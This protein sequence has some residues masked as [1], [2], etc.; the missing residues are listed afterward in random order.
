MWTANRLKACR[1]FWQAPVN[2]L[3]ALCSRQWGWSVWLFLSPWFLV[4]SLDSGVLF[5][6]ASSSF[7][8]FAAAS[9]CLQQLLVLFLQ[10]VEVFIAGFCILCCPSPE[11]ESGLFTPTPNEISGTEF[12]VKS[13]RIAT[14]ASLV[15]QMVKNLPAM[16]ETRVRSLG[17]E[18]P[19]EKGMATHSSI[20]AWRIVWTEEPSGL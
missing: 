17:W 15:A 6:R 19:P 12:W 2:Y 1:I 7:L 9:W 18:D 3:P 8:V 5:F 11:A 4:T 10:Q 14:R 20:L 13:K 16:Q